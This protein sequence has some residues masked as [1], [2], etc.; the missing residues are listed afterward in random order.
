MP[1]ADVPSPA[2]ALIEL[3]ATAIRNEL[4]AEIDAYPGQR[5]PE[6]AD[7]LN[8]AFRAVVRAIVR[9]ITGLDVSPDLVSLTLL[10][11]TQRRLTSEGWDERQVRFL[12]DQEPGHPDD[13]LTFLLL[14]SR[15][16]IEPLLDPDASNQV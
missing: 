7:P 15:P 6:R 13:W 4:G 1:D 2:L 3:I 8:R 16:Q 14:S 5:Q 11:V 9:H 10:Q 12:I